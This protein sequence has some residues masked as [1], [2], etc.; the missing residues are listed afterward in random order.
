MAKNKIER[1]DPEIAK[2]MCIRDR[3]QG[4]AQNHYQTMSD[5]QLYQLPV[6]DL[7]AE[8]CALFLWCTAQQHEMCIRDRR[9]SAG[10]RN[11]RFGCIH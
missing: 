5:E 2:K 10:G 1:I 3:V 6:A 11:Y 7:T 8:D 4:A 9:G